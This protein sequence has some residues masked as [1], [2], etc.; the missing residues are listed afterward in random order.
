MAHPLDSSFHLLEQTRATLD[1][2]RQLIH[3]WYASEPFESVVAPVKDTPYS[4]I[5]M[6][7]KIPIPTSIPLAVRSAAHDLRSALDHAGYA[8][9]QAS[10][11]AV[12]KKTYF[13]FAKT[14]AEFDKLR[15]GNSKDI[16]E[17]VLT[18][19][20]DCKAHDELDGNR[21]LYALATLRNINEHRY[22]VP[23]S[24]G[25]S[26]LN[27]RSRIDGQI[28]LKYPEGLNDCMFEPVLILPPRWSEESQELLFLLFD[29]RLGA[30]PEVSMKTY[31]GFGEGIFL[32]HQEIGGYLH[33]MTEL[34][35]EILRK[36]L[37]LAD[38]GGLFPKAGSIALS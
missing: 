25:A 24:H 30:Q 17:P 37:D 19:M 21:L 28:L 9:A 8:C 20:L 12:P 35:D 1:G 7:V 32:E 3:A 15:T 38:Q 5:S 2:L 11:I 22:L 26:L 13:P 33:P 29:P 27:V 6:R 4:A 16:P 34:V 31:I 23:C 10:G 14:K 18:Y 36:T